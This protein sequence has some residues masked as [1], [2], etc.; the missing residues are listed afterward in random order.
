MGSEMQR[1]RFHTVSEEILG[2]L[3]TAKREVIHFSRKHGDREQPFD[4]KLHH[5]L[6][7]SLLF[8]GFNAPGKVKA[9]EGQDNTGTSTR[10]R[11]LDCRSQDLHPD[12][13]V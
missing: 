7:V 2:H 5:K 10:G 6:F 13:R 11:P 4:R 12:R 3:A 1:R 8:L 9:A